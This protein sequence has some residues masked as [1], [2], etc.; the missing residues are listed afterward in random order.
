MSINPQCPAA[1]ADLEGMPTLRKC[2]LAGGITHWGRVFELYSLAV[3]CLFCISCALS[4]KLR[5]TPALAP[6]ALWW[7]VPP[8]AVSPNKSFSLLRHFVIAS[9][10]GTDS[11]VSDSENLSYSAQETGRG[12][13]TFS[14]SG[15][16]SSSSAAAAAARLLPYHSCLYHH[17]H[18]CCES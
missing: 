17:L 2:S 14:V 13:E 10:K 12:P 18:H 9:R 4:E 15:P 6:S 8:Q 16:S 11:L 1:G 5:Y 7:T 3:F